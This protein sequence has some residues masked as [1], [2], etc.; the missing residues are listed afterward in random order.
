[1]RKPLSPEAEAVLAYT[2]AHTAA[3][4]VLVT[5]LQSN[6]ALERGEF[7]ETLRLYIENSKDKNPPEVLTILHELRQSLL[8]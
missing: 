1:M 2:A 7:Q 5:C 4:Q 3:F 8:D 6:G